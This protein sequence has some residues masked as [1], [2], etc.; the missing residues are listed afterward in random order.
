M[1]EKFSVFRLDDGGETHEVA[2]R[3]AVDAR[4]LLVEVMQDA[5]LDDY[6]YHDIE[7]CEVVPG[8]TRSRR[9]YLGGTCWS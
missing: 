5:G 1:S 8:K 9:G 7:T 4:E 2:A 6:S 3:D